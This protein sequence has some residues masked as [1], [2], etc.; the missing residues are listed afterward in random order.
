M[1]SQC[2]CLAFIYKG[3]AMRDLFQQPSLSPQILKS[4]QW[5]ACTA[6]FA[7]VA[8]G[9]G[10]GGDG[11]PPAPPTAPPS[12]LNAQE[13][14]AYQS[15]ALRQVTLRYVEEKDETTIGGALSAGGRL[16]FVGK[17]PASGNNGT[18][19]VNNLPTYAASATGVC[20]DGGSQKQVDSLINN[21]TTYEAGEST[22]LTY[23][24]CTDGDLVLSG[25]DKL[26]FT[27]SQVF[28]PA[29]NNKAIKSVQLDETTDYT[30]STPSLGYSTTLKGVL[31]IDITDL[32][33]VYTLKNVA[34][35][36]NQ[37]SVVANM[38]ITINR[39][40]DF[41]NNQPF[42]VQSMAGSATV[43]GKAY[44]VTSSNGIPMR[45]V[46]AY[47]PRSGSITATASN[48]DKIITEFTATGAQ[49]SLVPAGTT[50]ASVTVAQCSQLL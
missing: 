33:R 24:G 16:Q 14:L 19:Q 20:K 5:A 40:N 27:G 29:P 23:T 15:W 50:T 9:G 25:T 2:L 36:F 42:T 30:Y 31:G 13:E 17:Y 7:L 26:N 18:G 49:C 46:V 39:S 35:T 45:S 8:C 1:P 4:F 48:G 37:G 44:T 28:Y 34:Y 22:T 10:G 32:R 21:N 3:L 41:G 38:A 43:D 6:A 47:L 11:T 12:A